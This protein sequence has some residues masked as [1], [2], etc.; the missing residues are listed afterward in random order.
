MKQACQPT[1]EEQEAAAAAIKK[2]HIPEWAN[3]GCFFSGFFEGIAY[4]QQNPPGPCVHGC[5]DPPNC[6]DC[7]LIGRIK[8]AAQ[9]GEGE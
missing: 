8:P 3:M 2:Y 7:Q 6:L 5:E 4:A 1:K 9:S